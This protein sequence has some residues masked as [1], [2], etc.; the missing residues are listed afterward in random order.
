MTY[1]TAAKLPAARAG[2]VYFFVEAERGLI[3]IGS[4]HDVEQRASVLQTGCADRL[5]VLGVIPHPRPRKLESHLHKM[6]RQDR[7]RAEWFR[8][9]ERMEEFVEI[10]TF[11][12]EGERTWCQLWDEA[13]PDIDGAWDWL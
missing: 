13:A 11:S 6:F 12:L 3:K 10:N 9:S 2:F 7:Y 1:P 8:Y 5:D 4:A